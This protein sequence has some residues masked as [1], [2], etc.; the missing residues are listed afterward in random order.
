MYVHPPINPAT[1]ILPSLHGDQLAPAVKSQKKVQSFSHQKFTDQYEV[2]HANDGYTGI[3]MC[4][5]GDVQKCDIRMHLDL[6]VKFGYMNKD[7]ASSVKESA[8]GV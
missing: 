6:L 7:L 3:D 8:D 4:Y 1:G 5:I 2:Y